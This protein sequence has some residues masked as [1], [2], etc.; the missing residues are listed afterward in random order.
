MQH[1]Q[2]QIVTIVSLYRYLVYPVYPGIKCLVV[3]R[4]II[5]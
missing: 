4:V 1:K 2:K 5:S 3:A